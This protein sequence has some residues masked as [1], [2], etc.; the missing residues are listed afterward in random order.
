MIY[1]MSQKFLNKHDVKMVK[2]NEYFILDGENYAVTGR[3]VNRVAI[4]TKYNRSHS[5]GGFCPENRLY[6]MI[7]KKKRGEDVNKEKYKKEVKKFIKDKTLVAAIAVA[8]KALI[9][10]GYDQPLNIFI[11]LPNRVYSTL[12]KKII[13]R[14]EKLAEVDFKFIFTQDDIK[15]DIK[16]LKKNLNKGQLKQIEKAAKRIEKRYKLKYMITDD[17]ED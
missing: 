11:V 14:M 1:V 9:A 5:V 12:S 13:K 3:S 8:F 15:D 6:T 17:D 4:A 10:N 2:Q 7:S 16:R